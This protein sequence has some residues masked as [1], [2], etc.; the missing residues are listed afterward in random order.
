MCLVT[1]QEPSVGGPMQMGASPCSEDGF[2]YFDG[3][4]DSVGVDTLFCP[5]YMHNL[6]DECT[7]KLHNVC[8]V[9]FLCRHIKLR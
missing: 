7:N 3:L 5:F 2:K 4:L 1:E 9:I 8:I 6:I